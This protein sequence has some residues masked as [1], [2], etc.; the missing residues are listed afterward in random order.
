LSQTETTPATEPAIP[1]DPIVHKSDAVPIWISSLAVVLATVLTIADEGW[2]RRPYKG[3]QAQY[4]ETYSAYLEK[5]A[6]KRSAFWYG[7]LT[8][9]DKF[10]KISKEADEAI[11]ASSEEAA[12]IQAQLDS[13]TDRGRKMT[14]AVKESKSEIAALSY[15]AETKA[16]AAGKH[17]VEHADEAKSQIEEIERIRGREIT[18]T[19]TESTAVPGQTEPSKAEKSETGKVGDLLA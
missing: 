11:A 16:H 15:L 14:E 13:A 8:K 3:V 2:F 6:A 7:V 18:F 1:P 10:T 19:W 17:E 12:K 9:L 4:R 5:V